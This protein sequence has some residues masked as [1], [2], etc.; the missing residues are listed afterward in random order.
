[1]ISKYFKV[2]LYCGDRLGQFKSFSINLKICINVL[3]SLNVIEANMSTP[4][5]GVPMFDRK[6]GGDS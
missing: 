2:N 3:V 4:N 5:G 1:M 6:L